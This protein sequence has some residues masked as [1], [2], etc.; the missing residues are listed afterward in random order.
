MPVTTQRAGP[1]LVRSRWAL[2]WGVEV[3]ALAVVG[4]P[5]GTWRGSRFT[6][7]GP[8]IM[9]TKPGDVIER[10]AKPAG[11]APGIEAHLLPEGADEEDLFS[12]VLR[13]YRKSGRADDQWWTA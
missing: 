9:Q 1:A 6:T 5:P 12:S 3:V 4:D 2:I 7:I 13:R 11:S 8:V 10:V